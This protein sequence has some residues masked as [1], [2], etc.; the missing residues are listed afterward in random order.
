MDPNQELENLRLQID[1]IDGQIL[2]LL[3]ERAGLALRIGRVK[4]T[5]GHEISDP[6]RER[7]VLHARAASGAAPLPADGVEAIFSEIIKWCRYIQEHD[8]KAPANPH[9]PEDA[10]DGDRHG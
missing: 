9:N 5:L 4:R 6:K 2:R 10:D 1:Q 7:D 8:G 3:S